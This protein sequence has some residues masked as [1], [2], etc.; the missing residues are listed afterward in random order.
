MEYD[1][2]LII[3]LDELREELV[4]GRIYSKSALFPNKE[5]SNAINNN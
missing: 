4:W 3:K 5:I 1:N 2:R